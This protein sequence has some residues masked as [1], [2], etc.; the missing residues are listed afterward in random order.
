MFARALRAETRSRAKDDIKRVHN[1]TE[2]VTKWEKKWVPVKDTSMM[3][4]KWVPVPEDHAKKSSFCRPQPNPLSS[5]SG[6]ILPNATKPPELRTEAP[7]PAITATTVTSTAVREEAAPSESKEQMD[8][9][10]DK[11][12]PVE[13]KKPC[14]VPP[15]VNE[16][17]ETSEVRE[18]PNGI[19][20]E[21]E[22]SEVKKMSEA[23]KEEDSTQ[24]SEVS[25]T[26]AENSDVTAV[27]TS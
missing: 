18:Y 13:A 16:T 20:S 8:T 6:S 15:A 27:R 2:K 14:D 12:P 3:V 21:N 1:S 26:P 4:F 11:A 25:N 9:S 10:E 23:E 22:A 24:P 19:S 17:T 7:L 5:N